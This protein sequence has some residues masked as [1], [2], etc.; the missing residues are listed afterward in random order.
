MEFYRKERIGSPILFSGRQKELTYFRK[1]I[2]QI[3]EEK[4][5]S[6]A[7][8]ARRKI[9]KTALLERLYNITFFKNDDIIP[10]YYEVKEMDIWVMD[11]CKDFF[12]T[13]ISQYMAFKTRKKEYFYLVGESDL[14]KLSLAAKNEKLDYLIPVIESVQ[15]A[16]A[17]EHIDDL[18]EIVRNVPHRL[19]EMQNEFIVQMIDEFQF[20]NDKI[21]WDKAK[22][23][24]AD[25]LA[26]GYLGTAE[27]KIAPLLVTGS[28]VGWLMNLLMTMLPSRFKFTFLQ[29]MPRDEAIEMVFNYS[30]F[31]NVPVT[32]ETAFLIAQLAEG[33]PFYISAIFRSNYE[34][35]D[36]TTT[37]G[38]VRTLEFETR[39][40]RGEIKYTWMEYVDK[41]FSKINDRNA[42]NIVLYLCKHRDREVTRKELLDELHLEMTDTELEKRLKALVKADIIQQ[43]E[44]NFDYTGVQDNIFDKVF[45]GVYQKEIDGFDPREIAREYQGA[46]DKLK[47]KYHRLQ[48]KYN[49]QKGYFAEYVILDQLMH[50]AVGKN[51]LLKSI[52]HNLPADFNFCRYDNAWTYRTAVIHA[53]GLTVDILARPKSPDPGDPADSKPGYSIIGEVKNRET[54]KFSKEEAAAFLEKFRHIKEKENLT[55]AIGFVF[56]RKGF[57]KEAETYLHTNH[58]AYTDDE[59]WL[60]L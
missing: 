51:T 21:F 29:N 14:K 41:A 44:T 60:N 31:F 20:L 34:E 11:F 15:H 16:I 5:K 27:S 57:T 59:R 8:L 9:G 28:W 32:E 38:L 17:H 25:S 7:I 13:F 4:S 56:S 42:K 47:Q 18:W 50:H 37:G 24:R 30:R 58:I 46:S 36:L 43:G 54:K 33:S 45:R 26:G 3:K 48:G 49:Y 19:A 6:T 52:T 35:K 2:T 39:D 22:K 1:W 40:N 23:N 12:R 10:F 55:R 53:K